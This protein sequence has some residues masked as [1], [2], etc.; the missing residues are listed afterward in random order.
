[1]VV[2]YWSRDAII[3][4]HCSRLAWLL[5]SRF[6]WQWWQ[7]L[8]RN[9]LDDDRPL[10]H[11]RPPGSHAHRC[12]SLALTRRPDKSLLSTVSPPHVEKRDLRSNSKNAK[13]QHPVV[14]CNVLS[15]VWGQNLSPATCSFAQTRKS[16][17][18]CSPTYCKLLCNQYWRKI[19]KSWMC[20][21]WD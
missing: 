7:S 10:S 14:R 15:G 9:M 16:V 1:M 21:I 17:Q 2:N 13:L 8:S 11:A 6:R 19:Y 5:K 3:P 12:H 18:F 20:F 4:M